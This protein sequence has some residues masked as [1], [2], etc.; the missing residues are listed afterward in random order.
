ME[1]AIKQFRKS[2]ERHFA[3]LED[4][5]RHLPMSAWEGLSNDGRQLGEVMDDLRADKSSMMGFLVWLDA[6]IDALTRYP[7][8][9]DDEGEDENE[10]I[11]KVYIKGYLNGYG[12]VQQK[13]EVERSVE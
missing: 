4:L 9:L 12:K 11:R 3:G 1:V 8:R 7:V 5:W 2:L 6:Y 10:V 13:Q